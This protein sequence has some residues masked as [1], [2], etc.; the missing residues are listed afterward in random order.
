M[1][2][3]QIV[4]TA[5]LLGLCAGSPAAGSTIVLP[6]A[7]FTASFAFND[8]QG[9][10]SSDSYSAATA[11]SGSLFGG[12]V[13]MVAGPTPS[14]FLTV[15]ASVLQS[16]NAMGQIQYSF[17]VTGPAGAAGMSVPI[18]V[19]ALVAYT[20]TGAR[21]DNPPTSF[22]VSA[23]FELNN[24]SFGY[25]V[26]CSSAGGCTPDGVSNVLQTTVRVGDVNTITLLSSAFIANFVTQTNT[27]ITARADPLITFDPS[28]DS[29]GLSLQFSPGIANDAAVPEPGS[30]GVVGTLAIAGLLVRRRFTGS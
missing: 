14:L 30:L 22:Q 24:F 27:V 21:F 8:G 2:I 16:V 29:T 1:R 23:G 9:G 15:G 25:A 18:D 17:M 3:H 12:R 11:P 5:G 28:F 26:G 10:S 7:S 13:T 4:W 19:D 6:D 20:V